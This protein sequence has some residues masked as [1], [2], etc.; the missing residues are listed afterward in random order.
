MINPLESELKMLVELFAKVA[1]I[2][3]HVAAKTFVPSK[4][5]E[6]KTSILFAGSDTNSE[7]VLKVKTSFSDLTKA[8]GLAAKN[9]T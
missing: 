7:E 5:F 2:G 8:S 1:V 3:V 9:S 6:I 4:S